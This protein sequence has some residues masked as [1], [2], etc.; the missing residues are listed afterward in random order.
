MSTAQRSA[1]DRV[2]A[3][4]GF[5]KRCSDASWE[6]WHVVWNPGC[7][8]A[9][10]K[11]APPRPDPLRH[12]GKR[13]RAAADRLLYHR[14]ERR[15]EARTGKGRGWK[16]HDRMADRW[17]NRVAKLHKRAGGQR[18]KALKLVLDDRDGRI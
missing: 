6:W 14:R 11:P 7:T 16:A 15:R 10:W 18:K 2:G 13:Q 4:Y 8:G 5:Q 17:Y 9:T 12:L 3:R 1:I